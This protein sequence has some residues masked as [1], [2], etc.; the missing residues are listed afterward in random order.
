MRRPTSPCAYGWIILILYMS[1]PGNCDGNCHAI[2][3]GNK[4]TRKLSTKRITGPRRCFLFAPLSLLPFAEVP[5]THGKYSFNGCRI[6]G[7][8]SFKNVRQRRNSPNSNALISVSFY[9]SIYPPCFLSASS[10]VG[11]SYPRQWLFYA[12][13]E[14][15]IEL[16][17]RQMQPSTLCQK[18]CRDFAI[19]LARTQ[20]VHPVGCCVGNDRHLG[21]RVSSG[22]N[23]AHPA[24]LMRPEK[25]P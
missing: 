8:V 15:L 22:L 19:P 12:R 9:C 13:Q 11:S 25:C 18:G 3:L 5:L 4:A 20:S 14:G 21:T 6:T 1:S 7:N 17:P 23:S 2:V 10:S 16:T 24:C